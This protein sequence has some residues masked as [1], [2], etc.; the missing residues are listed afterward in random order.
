[1]H[2][3]IH[4]IKEINSETKYCRS[5]KRKMRESRRPA[6]IVRRKFSVGNVE[7]I[8]GYTCL[9]VSGGSPPAA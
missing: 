7:V 5:L 3:Y 1:M 6:L 2:I 4:N 9:M 8:K